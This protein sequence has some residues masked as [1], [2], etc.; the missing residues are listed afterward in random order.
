MEK[1]PYFW[2]R[3]DWC[4]EIAIL[5]DE[6][7]EQPHLKFEELLGWTSYLPVPGGKL[8]HFCTRKC[9]AAFIDRCGS[10]VH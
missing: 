4:G 3:C 8:R 1:F 9:R 7:E 2:A 10:A 6:G 5:D